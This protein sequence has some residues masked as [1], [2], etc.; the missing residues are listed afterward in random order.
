MKFGAKVNASKPLSLIKNL[1]KELKTS[2][3]GA[4]AGYLSGDR[5][6]DSDGNETPLLAEVALWNNFGTYNSPPRP[7]LENAEK[8]IRKRAPKIVKAGIEDEKTLSKVVGEVAQDMRNCIVEAFTKY[9]YEA[10][11]DITIQGGW[12]KNKKSGK[13]FFVEGKGEGKRPLQNTSG[14]RDGVHA[15]TIKN[16][17][18]K[19]LG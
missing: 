13:P 6:K 8:D 19:L 10:N 5:H 2:A 11:A 12:M 15:A 3:T 9:D 14:L 7:F 16:G 17:Q 1:K 18:E 4:R